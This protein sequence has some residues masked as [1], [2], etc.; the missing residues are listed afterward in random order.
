MPELSANAAFGG[1]VEGSIAAALLQPAV[2]A[3]RCVLCVG[4][5][6]LTHVAAAASLLATCVSAKGV[7]CGWC[8]VYAWVPQQAPARCSIPMACG[9]CCFR[10]GGMSCGWRLRSCVSY[11]AALV[12]AVFCAP[13]RLMHICVAFVTIPAQP[14]EQLVRQHLG[15]FASC[16]PC[17]SVARPSNHICSENSEDYAC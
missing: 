16:I 15:W 10:A 11:P 12:S 8:F 9:V 13:A 4:C 7:A 1:L 6:L 14:A 17:A 5:A 3:V 2:A